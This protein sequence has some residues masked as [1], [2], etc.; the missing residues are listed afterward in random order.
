MSGLD[1]ARVRCAVSGHPAPMR[2][3]EAGDC[4]DVQ[5]LEKAVRY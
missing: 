1:P 5:H 4:R 3:C 2:S